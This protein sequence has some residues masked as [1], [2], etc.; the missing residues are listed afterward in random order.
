MDTDSFT[1]QVKTKGFYEDTGDGFKKRFGAS[2][3]EAERSLTKGRNKK[4]I[5][6]MKHELRRKNYDSICFS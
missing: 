3:Y 6:L 1:I 4:V 5:G 2:K